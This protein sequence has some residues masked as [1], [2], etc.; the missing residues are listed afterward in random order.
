MTSYIQ[1]ISLIYYNHT[2]QLWDYDVIKLSS[3]Q[4]Y[5]NITTNSCGSI[6]IRIVHPDRDPEHPQNLL[7]LFLGSKHTSGES[8]MQIRL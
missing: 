8:L 1:P 5:Q 4:L 6:V 2:Q 7:G 3:I